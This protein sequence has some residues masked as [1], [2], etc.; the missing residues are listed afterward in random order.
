M[1]EKRIRREFA[2]IQDAQ[3][4]GEPYGCGL[5]ITF[6]QGDIFDWLCTY[7]CPQFYVLQGL[8]RFSPYSGYVIHFR[9][10][11][12]SDY[13]FEPFKLLV[14]LSTHALPER[15]YMRCFHSPSPLVV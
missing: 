9:I 14:T 1:A 3:A 6:N 12:P 2:N 4:K 10:Q 7:T 15:A 11:F 13:P 8:Q 5:A